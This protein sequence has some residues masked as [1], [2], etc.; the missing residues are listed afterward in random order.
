MVLLIVYLFIY[1]K[2]QQ[3]SITYLLIY[4]C[5]KWKNMTNNHQL[6]RRR[7]Y[8]LS[9]EFRRRRRITINLLEKKNF[10]YI[11]IDNKFL[12][13]TISNDYNNSEFAS[14]RIGDWWGFLDIDKRWFAFV[15]LP[16]NLEISPPDPIEPWPRLLCL[17]TT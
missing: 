10:Y 17:I 12:P 2:A 9:E 13:W 16:T 15:L 11:I 14:S 8:L 1:F 3:H 4:I 6:R 5:I 7:I